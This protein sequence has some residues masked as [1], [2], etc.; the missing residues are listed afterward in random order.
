MRILLTGATSF[1]GHW[2]AW[3]LAERGHDVTVALWRHRDH[4]E[5]VRQQRLRRDG[6]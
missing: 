4:Y 2:F 3:E 1:T 5:G 6:K